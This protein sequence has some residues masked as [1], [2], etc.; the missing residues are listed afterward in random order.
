METSED[1]FATEREANSVWDREQFKDYFEDFLGDFPHNV[2]S[3]LIMW[4]LEVLH[5]RAESNHRFLDIHPEW[6]EDCG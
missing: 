1:I 5:Y 3:R 2:L 6:L 4:K